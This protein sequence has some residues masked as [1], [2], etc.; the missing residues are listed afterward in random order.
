MFYSRMSFGQRS[1]K[2]TTLM[3]AHACGHRCPWN[4]LKTNVC[5][6]RV[7]WSVFWNVSNQTEPKRKQT[8][9]SIHWDKWAIRE[10]LRMG[11]AR[12]TSGR[13]ISRSH[14]AKWTFVAWICIILRGV[15]IRNRFANLGHRNFHEN[16]LRKRAVMNTNDVRWRCL[17]PI[18]GDGVLTIKQNEGNDVPDRDARCQSG[19]MN[20]SPKRTKWS[21]KG[22]L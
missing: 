19:V 2:Q 14:Q 11:G 4:G 7:L 6:W 5:N 3:L 8:D 9:R 21:E 10:C 22:R 18:R 16:V 20:F 12:N 17:W 1:S 15:Q 13:R